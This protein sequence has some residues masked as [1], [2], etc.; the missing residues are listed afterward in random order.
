[1]NKF[2]ETV[3]KTHRNWPLAHS[4]GGA[5]RR[6]AGGSTGGE[7]RVNRVNATVYSVAF[8]LNPELEFRQAHVRTGVRPAATASAP[9]SMLYG[10]MHD[11]HG[12]HVTPDPKGR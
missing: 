3:R 4:L 1:M 5:G 7:H 12:Q 9:A 6:W 2:W 8:C 10:S 11:Q